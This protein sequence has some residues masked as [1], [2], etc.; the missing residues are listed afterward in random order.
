MAATALKFLFQ[1]KKKNKREKT[2]DT[3]RTRLICNDEK[4]KGEPRPAAGSACF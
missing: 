1:V 4:K 3:N 2:S